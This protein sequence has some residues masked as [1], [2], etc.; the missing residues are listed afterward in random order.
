MRLGDFDFCNNHNQFFWYDKD[1][2][3]ATVEIKQ[4][5]GGKWICG[6]YV[7]PAYRKNG[8]GKDLLQFSALLG[9]KKLSVDKENTPALSLYRKLGFCIFD[10]DDENFFMQMKEIE[11]E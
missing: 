2:L 11:H 8:L 6:V 3:V 10:E 5:K 7:S 9:G 4:E 1:E